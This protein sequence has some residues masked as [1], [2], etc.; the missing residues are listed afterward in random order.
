MVGN[1]PASLT[2]VRMKGNACR[3]IGLESLKVELRQSTTTEELVRKI[4][5]LNEDENVHGILLQHPVPSQIDEQ[6]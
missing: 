3:R 5:E 4:Q 2:Y 6:K 1:N